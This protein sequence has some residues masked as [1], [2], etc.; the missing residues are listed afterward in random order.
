MGEYLRVFPYFGEP[1]GEPKYKEEELISPILIDK[2]SNN[3]FII[4]NISYVT[5]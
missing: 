4:H 5:F 2:T 3:P 1:L